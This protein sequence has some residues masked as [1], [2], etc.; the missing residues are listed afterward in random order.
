MGDWLQAVD[1]K[2]LQVV[3][4]A[5]SSLLA[6]VGLLVSG[7]VGWFGYRNN[8]GWKPVVLVLV[9]SMEEHDDTGALSVRAKLEVLN[10]RKYPI[11]LRSATILF[12]YEKA[13]FEGVLPGWFWLD[14]GRRFYHRNSEV[15]EGGYGKELAFECVFSS[16]SGEEFHES[17][18]VEVEFYDIRSNK[19]RKA[20]TESE[21]DLRKYLAPIAI[22]DAAT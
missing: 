4:I 7:V 8:F 13:L 21:I 17:Y 22:S 15:I 18:V 5:A 20:R 19:F 1:V 16:T 9:Q 3:Q 2:L 14:D 10:R 12:S 11:R 6:L